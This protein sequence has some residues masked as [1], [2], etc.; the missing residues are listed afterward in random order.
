[1]SP[2]IA[3]NSVK[4]EIIESLKNSPKTMTALA[5]QTGVG[6]YVVRRIIADLTKTRQVRIDGHIGKHGIYAY[7][8]EERPEDT[9]PRL[10]DLINKQQL[11]ITRMLIL[12]GNEENL[13]GTKAAKSI[14]RHVANLMF[15]SVQAKEGAPVGKDLSALREQVTQDYLYVQNLMNLYTQIIEEPRFWDTD[16]L[17]KMTSDPDFSLEEVLNAWNFYND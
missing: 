1:M 15:L 8:G 12:K 14:V 11:K 10:V 16:S 17:A 3:S 5:D 9:I 13:K 6:Y 4:R 7:C 2:N